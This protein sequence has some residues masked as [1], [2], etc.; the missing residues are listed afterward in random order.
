MS[1][2]PTL[3]DEAE[4]AMDNDDY[5]TTSELQE[6][7]PDKTMNHI[8]YDMARD[9]AEVELNAKIESKYE[10]NEPRMKARQGRKTYAT[11]PK[12]VRTDFEEAKLKWRAI[13]IDRKIKSEQHMYM[14][15]DSSATETQSRLT[16]TEH[17]SEEAEFEDDEEDE[18]A[19]MQYKLQ[20]M[21]ILE[22]N[23]PRYG[24]T[25][26]ITA[27]SFEE[28][29]DHAP[30]NVMIVIHIYQDYLE[31]CGRMNFAIAQIAQSYPNIKFMRARSDRLG[32]DTYPDVGLP[33]FVVYKNGKQLQNHIAVHTLVPNPFTVK[34]VEHFLIQHKVMKP[35]IDI[36]QEIE[37]QKQTK[38]KRKTNVV[39]SNNNNT[40]YRSTADSDSDSGLDID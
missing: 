28:E 27:Y 26:E 6:M 35:V 5:V 32:L 19:L 3:L 4:E 36:A 39:V 14:N 9:E 21:A 31:R 30:P 12:G 20:K 29:V 22:A 8:E 7:Y 2:D 1:T 38:H 33:T 16:I 40:H 11:G 15:L 23:R 18:E 17:K 24:L 13:D 34:D 10:F 37:A 25:K